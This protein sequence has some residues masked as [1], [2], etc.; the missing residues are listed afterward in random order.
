MIKGI[1]SICEQELWHQLHTE[2]V[3]SLIQLSSEFSR[4]SIR[5]ERITSQKVSSVYWRL[6]P[7]YLDSISA[8]ENE[9]SQSQPS[10]VSKTRMLL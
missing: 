1:H 4:A 10:E 3:A 8:T 9:K 6:L 2:L 7:W 5:N